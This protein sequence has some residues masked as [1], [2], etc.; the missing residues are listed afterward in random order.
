MEAILIAGFT[1]IV[2]SIITI[3]AIKVDIAWIKSTIKQHN[4]RLIKLEE[5]THA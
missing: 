5:K 4:R 2:S 1:G 3:T